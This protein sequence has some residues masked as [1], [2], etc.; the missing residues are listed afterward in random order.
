MVTSPEDRIKTVLD[1]IGCDDGAHHKQWMLDQIVRILTDCPTVTKTAIDAYGKEYTYEA[2][3][4][5]V[6]YQ[7]W[8][9]AYQ[10]GED[11]PETYSWDEGIPP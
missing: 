6:E 2:L 7:E 8:L 11:G 9:A 10:D 1:S 3:G 4:E 5:S